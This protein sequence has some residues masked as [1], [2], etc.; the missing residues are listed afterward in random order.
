MTEVVLVI[1]EGMRGH[2]GVVDEGGALVGIVSDG[3]LRRAL[4][5]NKI[6]ANAGEIMSHS[7]RTVTG[8]MRVY[9]VI[10]LLKTHKISAVFAI[11]EAGKP[12]GLLHIQELLRL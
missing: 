3:D 2:A 9:E 12:V 7:P 4:T 6:N 1:T 11:D 8:D 10:E 5:L